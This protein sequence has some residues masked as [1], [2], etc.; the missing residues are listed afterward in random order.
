MGENVYSRNIGV[1]KSFSPNFYDEISPGSLKNPIVDLTTVKQNS[2]G[3][4]N[5]NQRVAFVGS[6]SGHIYFIV[7][8]LE[9]YIN[10][11][12]TDANLN[13][14][15]NNFIKAF[16]F[17]YMNRGYHNLLEM[18]HV[19]SDPQL[20][21]I[22]KKNHIEIDL[23]F[24]DQ[25]NLLKHALSDTQEY[26]KILSLKSTLHTELLTKHYEKAYSKEIACEFNISLD[27]KD[28][29]NSAKG[30]MI[31]NKLLAKHGI[32][33]CAL[34][35]NNAGEHSEPIYTF[36]GTIKIPQWKDILKN[37]TKELAVNHINP[38]PLP[39][40]DFDVPGS[41]YFSY[42]K[43]GLTAKNFYEINNIH[44]ASTIKQ[45]D[46][47]IF[48][49]ANELKEN[50]TITMK[51]LADYMNDQTAGSKEK[52]KKAHDY[53]ST[54]L[55]KIDLMKNDFNGKEESINQL[56]QQY[57][58]A[59]ELY[60]RSKIS[61]GTTTILHFLNLKEA[62]RYDKILSEMKIANKTTTM[63]DSNLLAGLDHDYTDEFSQLS[64]LSENKSSLQT[65]NHQD[66]DE[67]GEGEIV[68]PRHH[69]G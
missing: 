68:H 40:K 69:I 50:I 25:D 16:M 48:K 24:S 52:A 41:N 49:Q 2:T 38:G 37:L 30:L 15:I 35:E 6:I 31:I 64:A 9:K 56:E 33:A 8:M 13:K 67:E 1:M 55:T 46:R 10:T 47:P 14:D 4:S 61:Q 20:Q 45:P 19:F 17:T 39:K 32:K 23:S 62:P 60:A 53:L 58:E 65:N 51:K 7:A 34:V 57:K 11:H 44:I 66:E 3:Y 43:N 22:F 28:P 5:T 18:V 59:G 63:Q 36:K 12:R 21:E 29:Q 42:N 26:A 27:N 54:I